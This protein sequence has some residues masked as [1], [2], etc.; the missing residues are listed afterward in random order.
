MNR[1]DPESFKDLIQYLAMNIVEQ[2][3]QVVTREI[4]GDR[5]TVIELHVAQS[6]VGLVIGKSG[7]MALALRTLLTAL[8]AKRGLRAVLEI[9]EPS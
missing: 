7:R 8:A 3:D 9:A 4:R 6:D 1:F 2:P 5:T